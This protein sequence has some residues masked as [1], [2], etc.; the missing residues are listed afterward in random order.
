MGMYDDINFSM[1]CIN[2]GSLIKGF[3]SKD[4]SCKMNT[5]EP[6]QVDNFYSSCPKCNAWTEFNRKMI[7][8]RI[9][10]FKE[11]LKEFDIEVK[12]DTSNVKNTNEV[13]DGK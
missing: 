8:P 4:G 7:N 12:L 5:L 13:E 1:K 3:Q 6:S 11:V 9:M 10:T 2:C